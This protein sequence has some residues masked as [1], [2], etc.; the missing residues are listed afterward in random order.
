MFV[1]DIGLPDTDGNELA[2]QLRA[3]PENGHAVLI[4]LTGYGLGPDRERTSAAGF[5][6]HLVKPVDTAGLC[7][8]LAGIH[9]SRP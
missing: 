7:R 5:D 2:R 1:L 6:H 3:R 4:A 9:P 8:I